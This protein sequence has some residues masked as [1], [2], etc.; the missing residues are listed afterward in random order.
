MLGS[1]HKIQSAGAAG[2][3]RVALW[4]RVLEFYE[5][6]GCQIL[7]REVVGLFFLGGA[8]VPV[9]GRGGRGRR[10]PAARIG[11]RLAPALSSPIRL[12]ISRP[13]GCIYPIPCAWPVQGQVKEKVSSRWTSRYTP[14]SCLLHLTAHKYPFVPKPFFLLGGFGIE[15][16]AAESES[17]DPGLWLGGRRIDTMYGHRGEQGQRQNENKSFLRR[18]ALPTEHTY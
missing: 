16:N 17:I 9:S 12:G 13:E 2:A 14:A 18:A 15:H 11:T 1:V 10:G 4:S 7:S 6:L 3:A 8:T 5:Y